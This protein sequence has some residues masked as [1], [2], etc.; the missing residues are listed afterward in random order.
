M[1]KLNKRETRLLPFPNLR[2]L[3]FDYLS[4][5]TD[6][7]KLKLRYLRLRLRLH[8]LPMLHLLSLLKIRRLPRPRSSF[9]LLQLY[10]LSQVPPHL[11]AILRQYSLL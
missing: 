9:L 11:R 5:L 3:Q 6:K 1:I 2:N 7:G 10:N 4:P 8:L